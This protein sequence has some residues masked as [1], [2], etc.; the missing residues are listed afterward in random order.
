MPIRKTSVRA[1]P[2]NK[3]ANK[4][5]IRSNGAGVGTPSRNTSQRGSDA[6]LGSQDSKDIVAVY[7][8]D[9][10]NN[11]QL[12]P[13]TEQSSITNARARSIGSR[14]R[15]LQEIEKIKKQKQDREQRKIEEE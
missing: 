12:V 5:Q 1:G 7:E 11:Q 9:A 3:T 2:Y 14:A 4:A 15:A 8:E 13:F 6:R 10:E